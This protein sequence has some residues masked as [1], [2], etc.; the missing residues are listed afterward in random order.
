MDLEVVAPFEALLFRLFFLLS[1]EGLGERERE[2]GMEQGAGK[3]L[4]TTPVIQYS[5]CTP[6]STGLYMPDRL[7]SLSLFSLF[8]GDT[9]TRWLARVE[10][11][12][13]CGPTSDKRPRSAQQ[14]RQCKDAVAELRAVR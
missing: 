5:R 12:R 6:L 4:A 8:L 1:W 7:V 3:R 14:N 9:Y 11:A 2:R 13:G 10:C